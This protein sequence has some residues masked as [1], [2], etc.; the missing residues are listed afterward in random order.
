MT[1]TVFIGPKGA[2]VSQV[3]LGDWTCPVRVD[4]NCWHHV[5]KLLLLEHWD[6]EDSAIVCTNYRGGRVTVLED[7]TG[8]NFFV[9]EEEAEVA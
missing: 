2:L 3:Q 6:D 9:G 4:E 5:L 8:C 7:D 1:A